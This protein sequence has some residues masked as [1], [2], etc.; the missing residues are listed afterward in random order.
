MNI[1]KNLLFLHGHFTN[2]RMDEGYG[3]SYGNR[4]EGARLLRESWQDLADAKR[5]ARPQPEDAAPCVCN[6]G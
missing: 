2:P 1:F 6:R 3:P 5:Q 4:I